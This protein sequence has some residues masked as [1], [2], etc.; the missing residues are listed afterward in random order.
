MHEN[1]LYCTYNHS[2]PVLKALIQNNLTI[3]KTLKENKIIGTVASFNPN[4]IK[5]KYDKIELGE[6]NTKSAITYKD[7]NLNLNHDE[8][9]K[10]RQKEIEN[11][12]LITLSKYKKF[13]KQL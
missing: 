5:N 6:L 2:K 9:I 1:S 13:S 4:L 11:S 10:N 3:G 8:I 12:N 7:L